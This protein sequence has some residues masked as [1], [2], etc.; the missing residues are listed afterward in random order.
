[1]R[2]HD[3]FAG[4][5]ECRAHNAGLFEAAAA[6]VALLEIADER[7][8]LERERE[9]RLEWQCERAREVFAEM[10]VDL[11]PTV[12]ENFPRIKNVL[13]IECALNLAQDFKQLV[14]QLVTH[15]LGARD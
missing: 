9:R 10:I 14:T 1:T 7:A 3:F 11:V 8:V 5:H 12:A 13:R 2:G 4:G 6:A 15:I